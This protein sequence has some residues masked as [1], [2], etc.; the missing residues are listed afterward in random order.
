MAEWWRRQDDGY[1][2]KLKFDLPQKEALERLTGRMPLL[3]RGLEHIFASPDL[4]RQVRSGDVKGRTSVTVPERA[5][6]IQA[7]HARLVGL[8]E[9]V[10]LVGAINRYASDKF[11]EFTSSG[12]GDAMTR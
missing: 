12:N 9:V 10:R 1:P 3:L 5:Q 7:V 4:E 2:Q 8:P 11:A 6:L